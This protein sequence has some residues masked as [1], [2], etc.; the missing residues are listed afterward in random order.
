MSELSNMM[1]YESAIQLMQQH[2]DMMYF[3]GP[4]HEGAILEAEQVLNLRFPES[5]RR[6]LSEFGAGSFGG[7]EIYGVI[8]NREAQASVPNTVWLT[9][10]LRQEVELPDQFVVVSDDGMGGYIC[11]DCSS[12]SL[13]ESPIVLCYI[14]GSQV[15]EAVVIAKD[16]SDYLLEQSKIAIE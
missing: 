4:C 12:S 16:F 11:L 9:A 15:T 1:M 8:C 5:Y 13:K 14:E 6:F 7:F 3:C 2:P 10:K